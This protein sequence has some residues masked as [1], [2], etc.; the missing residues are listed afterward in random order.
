MLYARKEKQQSDTIIVITNL[1]PLYGLI[2]GDWTGYDL[3]WL[4]W[5]ET[6]IIGLLYP[7]R[8]SM[9]CSDIQGC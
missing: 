7:L 6:L 1:C 5:L 4:Y 2:V 3:L 9:L 8:V